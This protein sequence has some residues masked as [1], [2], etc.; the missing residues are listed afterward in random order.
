MLR[1]CWPER[2][3]F[4]IIPFNDEIV[5]LMIRRITPKKVPEI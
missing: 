2:R 4:V 3:Y 1:G 5:Q